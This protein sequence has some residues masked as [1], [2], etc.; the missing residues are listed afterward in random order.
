VNLFAMDLS[1]DKLPRHL[2][3]AFVL[4]IA[5]YAAFFSCDMRMR[6]RKGPWQVEFQTNEAGHASITVNQPALRITNVQIVFAGEIATTTGQVTFDRPQKPVPFGKTKF[7]DLTYLPGS[8]AFDFF[9]HELEL[10]PRTLYL[11][12]KEYP[13][14]ASSIFTLT[15]DQKLPPGASQDPREKKRRRPPTPSVS[16]NQ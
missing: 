16:T 3:I 10:L 4:A 2:L 15:P 13:W 12:K 9:G 11:N 14:A 8:V 1:S 7:E 5:I 6:K